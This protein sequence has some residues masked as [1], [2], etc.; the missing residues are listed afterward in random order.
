MGLSILEIWIRFCSVVRLRMDSGEEDRGD[1]SR[2][3]PADEH[4][5]RSELEDKAQ[6]ARAEKIEREG[7]QGRPQARTKHAQ[8]DE[9]ELKV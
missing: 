9:D 1:K 2:H 4:K 6:R 7:Q 3:T 8:R 5:V